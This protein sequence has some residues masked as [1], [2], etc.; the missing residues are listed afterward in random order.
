MTRFVL[1]ICGAPGAGKSSLAAHLAATMR[2]PA[3]Q[4]PMDGFHL[5]DVELERQ[6]VLARK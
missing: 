6:G 2:V 4:V 1:G 3:A 5:A